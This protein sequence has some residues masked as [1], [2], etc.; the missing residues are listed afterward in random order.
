MQ[1]QDTIFPTISSIQSK[2]TITKFVLVLLIYYHYL[3]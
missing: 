1:M 3:R 2:C